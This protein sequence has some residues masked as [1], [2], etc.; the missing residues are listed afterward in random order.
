M[1]VSKILPQNKITVG[2]G[3][4][5]CLLRIWA[6]FCETVNEEINL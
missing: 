2:F 3:N 6:I 5:F 1:Y 4:V